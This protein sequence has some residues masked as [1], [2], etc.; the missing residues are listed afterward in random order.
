MDSTKT[1]YAMDVRGVMAPDAGP[2]ST[3]TKTG[4]IERVAGYVCEKWIIDSSTGTRTD[5]CVAQGI[6]WFDWTGKTGA[7]GSSWW[8]TLTDGRYFPLR[9]VTHDVRGVETERMEVTS[10]ERKHVDDVRVEL[11]HGYALVSF[12]SGATSPVDAGT[13]P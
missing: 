3:V 9:A 7:G 8:D 11:P 4:S 2:S 12:A 13:V 5:A 6:A 10:I 1:V